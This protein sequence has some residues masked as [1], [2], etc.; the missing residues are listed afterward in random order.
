M[1]DYFIFLLIVSISFSCK[2]ATIYSGSKT[3]NSSSW[4]YEDEVAFSFDILHAVS[5]NSIALD[6]IH[7]AHYAYENLYITVIIEQ[8]SGSSVKEIIS[9]PLVSKDGK[10]LGKSLS[11]Q[12][13]KRTHLLNQQLFNEQGNYK[14]TI[15]QNSR[16]STLNGIAEIQFHILS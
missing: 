9:I 13:K 2:K 12:R 7:E 11:N 1:K 4:A 16:E 5:Q 10:W 6:I 15:N 3:I 8:P 14:I